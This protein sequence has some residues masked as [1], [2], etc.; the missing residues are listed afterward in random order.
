MMGMVK[1]HFRAASDFLSQKAVIHLSL[2]VCRQVSFDLMCYMIKSHITF[3]F[4]VI[5]ERHVRGVKRQSEGEEVPSKYVIQP[6][7]WGLIPPFYKVRVLS[8]FVF[9]FLFFK[10][11]NTSACVLVCFWIF[12][13]FV[14]LRYY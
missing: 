14:N 5:S 3:L 1:L 10:S 2:R 8:S 6:M 11:M 7:M 4:P 12:S 9:S 13:F